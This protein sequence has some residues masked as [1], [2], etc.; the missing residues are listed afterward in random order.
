MSHN[1]WIINGDLTVFRSPTQMAKTR[2]PGTTR[3]IL[4][5]CRLWQSLWSRRCRS[6]LQSLPLCRYP[7]LRNECRSHACPMGISSW[8]MRGHRNGRSAMDGK[9]SF[10]IK[11]QEIFGFGK[12]RFWKN[13]GKK[14]EIKIRKYYFKI[15]TQQSRRRFWGSHFTRPKTNSG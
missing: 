12:N 3:T 10:M 1:S 8:T 4:L 7:N 13:F 15:F 14:L 9:V 5:R 6:S 2:F 11:T